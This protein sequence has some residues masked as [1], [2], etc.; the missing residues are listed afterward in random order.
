MESNFFFEKNS[1]IEYFLQPLSFLFNFLL[2]CNKRKRDDEILI[3]DDGGL[4]K[5]KKWRD[6]I[7]K[8]SG[9]ALSSPSSFHNTTNE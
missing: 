5:K 6:E 8:F 3:S 1:P 2:W 9:I 4:K 7:L